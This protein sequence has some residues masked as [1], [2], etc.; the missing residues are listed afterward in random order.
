MEK[1]GQQIKGRMAMKGWV[2]PFLVRQ[3]TEHSFAYY[4]LKQGKKPD[5]LM[6]LEARGGNEHV[7][8]AFL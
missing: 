3:D 8:T 6:L 4:A 5:E 1:Q 7:G 2:V